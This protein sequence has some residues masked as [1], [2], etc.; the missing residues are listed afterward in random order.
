M[1][2]LLVALLLTI[3]VSTQANA[4][5]KSYYDYASGL[6]NG[7]QISFSTSM[8]QNY[9]RSNKSYKSLIDR[10][11]HLFSKYSWFQNL[12]DRYSF[13]IAE[14]A[15]YNALLNVVEVKVTLVSTDYV[16]TN[17]VVTSR[18][19]ISETST[20][21]V[22]SETIDNNVTE[23]AVV[24]KT[25]T[26]PV[27]TVHWENT[28]TIKTYSDGTKGST[29]D[30]KTVKVENT[31]DTETK[32]ER[33]II[34][35]Y[36]LVVEPE[37]IVEVVVVEEVV[38]EVVEVVEVV[39][40]DKPVVVVITEAEYLARND[41][42]YTDTET[43]R[44]AV[45]NMNSRI[46][47]TYVD[48]V[49]SKHYGNH[50]EVI[51]AGAAWS[52][53]Y[54]GK[55][56]TIAILDTGID[57]DHAE[58]TDS[59]KGSKCFTRSC[60][61]GYETIDDLN[62]YSHGTHIA[63]IA[64][65]NLDGVGTTGVAYD[66]DLL[67]AKTAYNSGS[68]DFTVV[69][70]AIEWAV[71]NGADVLNMSGN[72]NFDNVYKKSIV[73]MGDGFYKSTDTRGRNGITYDKYGYAG[74]LD[75][76]HYY[77]NIVEAMKGHEAV[78]V[79]SA[80]NQ[81]TDVVGQ[82][83][84][85]A[86]DAEVGDRVLIVGNYDTRLNK[87]D[88]SSNKAGTMCMAFNADGTC[89]SNAKISDSYLMAPG[90][91]VA[92]TDAN[93]S[94]R[95]NSGTSQAAPMVT[96]AVAIV[97]QMWPH[98]TGA[99]LTKLLLNT[100]NKDIP[101]YD[102]N[103]HGQGLL[104]LN[105]ATLPQ[106]AIG[107]PTTGRATGGKVDVTNS[108]II[109]VQ[110]GNISS[111][112]SVMVIDDYDRDYYFDA[113]SMVQVNDT[114]TTSPVLAAQNGFAPDYYIGFSGGTVIPTGNGSTFLSVNESNNNISLLQTYNKFSLGLVN[115]SDTYLGNYANSTLMKVDG[116]NTAY[117]G[118][119]DSIDFQGGFKV[120]GSATMGATKLDVD[121]SSM[122]K[123]ADVMMSNSAT[124]GVSQT[125]GASTFGFVTSMP[126]SITSGNANFNLPTSVSSTGDINNSNV[127]SSM[128]ADKRE[129]DFGLFYNYNPTE[130][131]AFTANVELRT[132]YAGTNENMGTAGIS[133][134]VKF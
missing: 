119:N 63:G 4:G 76:Q 61:L 51:G 114:R 35:Q 66:A 25:F 58:F 2:K 57:L 26:T 65:A 3:C 86:L 112:T 70:E 122:L 107:L 20:T 14:I 87:I 105:E 88:R 43:Y 130:N 131:T 89:T 132:N 108:G 64:A 18:G 37:P 48:T 29:N 74:L 116:S 126:V 50:L 44:L 133:Y 81:G 8:V 13:Q 41:V 75:S 24:T 117:I 110:G 134:M 42:T 109:A 77:K 93:G 90:R 17:G 56:S 128:E 125:T 62:K 9:E 115:E 71:Q 73:S 55:G 91:Y 103:V 54:T 15:K 106:G 124:V 11:D 129:L 38:E 28:N 80:G 33:T 101:N 22:V 84:W 118:Y 102:E 95:T 46:N 120:Y 27:K 1:K 47:Q 31:V 94:Y 127:S 39:E 67:I 123:S 72:Y 69:D 83:G 82:P 100:A 68:Y 32:V 79:M 111:L 34:K 16:K 85:I 53:G 6:N 45:S 19:T 49:L 99:N 7:L 12:K 96:G 5:F 10:Y 97:H 52:R 21:N 104:D 30:T 121:S 113:N 23:Y 78:L 98:M 40:E 59:I 92:S 36:A 60:K